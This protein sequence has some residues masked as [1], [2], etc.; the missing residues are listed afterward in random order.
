MLTK[1]S[2]TQ[3]GLIALGLLCVIASCARPVQ[4]DVLPDTIG[5]HAFSVHSNARDKV[6]GERW[7]NANPGLYARWDTIVVGTYYN[8]IRRQSFYAG[9]VYPLSNHF[10]VV[11]GAVTGYDGPG[12]RAKAVMPMVIPSFHMP[13]TD[14]LSARVNLAVGIGKGSATAVNFALE[15][16]L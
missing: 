7:N 3:R 4:A 1:L 16:R 12:Y 8:S 15:Y 13:I 5:V 11:L 6:S 10:D 14:N 2:F 9:Y